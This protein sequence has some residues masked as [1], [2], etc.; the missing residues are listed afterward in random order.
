MLR[1]AANSTP[2]SAFQ[3]LGLVN[4]TRISR[5]DQAGMNWLWLDEQVEPEPAGIAREDRLRQIILGAFG[6]SGFSITPT[7][8]KARKNGT[9][10]Q[11]SADM[12]LPSLLQ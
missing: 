2:R 6:R 4:E 7:S 9:A 1:I 5:R 12:I 10:N 11:I 3:T 8:I